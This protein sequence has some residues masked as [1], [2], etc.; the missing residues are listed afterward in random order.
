MSTYLLKLYVTGQT[1]RSR[2]AI[3]NL[4]RICEEE[5]RGQYEMHVIDVLERPQLAEDEKIL[6]T[7]TVV[8]EL[9]MPIRRIIGDLSDAEKVL[10]GL[11]LL[12][13]Q[14]RNDT[15]SRKEEGVDLV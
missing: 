9:P 8:K 1:P 12:P 14:P 15:A 11:D 6:A 7:P 5:L 13:C 4:R 2:R 3:E 10:L